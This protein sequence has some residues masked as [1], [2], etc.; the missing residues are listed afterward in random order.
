M[1]P[2]FA[3]VESG[4]R[5]LT[6]TAVD[7]HAR[8]QGLQSGLP[9]ADARAAVPG[10]L[11]RPA[12]RARDLAALEALAVWCGRYGPHR[13]LEGWDGE[14]PDGLWVDVTGVPHLFGGETELVRDL[15]ARLARLGLTARIGLADTPGAAFALA[16]FADTG[17]RSS[18]SIAPAGQLRPALADLPVEALRLPHECVLV[19]KRLGLR[20]IGQLYDLPR[21]ALAQ[22]F[23]NGP[24]AEKG[25]SV[26]KSQREAARLAGLVLMRLDQAL[27]NQ[28]EPR[29]PLLEPP[30][31]LVRRTFMEPLISAPGVEHAVGG[32][33]A[34]LCDL[35]ESQARGARR[36]VLDMYR[37]DATAARIGIGLSRPGRDPGHVVALMVERLCAID[38]GFGIDVMTLAAHE[39]EVLK[40][41]QTRLP[42][43]GLAAAVADAANLIDRL[44]NRLGAASVVRLEAADSHLPE[45]AERRVPA[46]S[47]PASGAAATGPPAVRPLALRPSFLLPRPEPI[48]VLA[49][50]PEGPP[51]RFTWRRLTRR[52]TRADGPE[53]IE[54]EWWRT[55]GWSADAV[56]RESGLGRARDYYAVED[57]AGAR[58]WVFRA[59]LYGRDLEEGPPVWFLH[60]VFA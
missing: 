40:H 60:G 12:E 36:F 59:G 28:L 4:P 13:N 50:V 41:D 29:A 17:Q 44:S 1:P 10:L 7:E 53:R 2:P 3:L 6:L 58:Y 38:A 42:A 19:L 18:W 30:A 32:L 22:R 20:R 23:R 37:T 15:A 56:R 52:V 14:P 33:V 55:I 48:A 47:P 5:G 51:I 27:G 43:G 49:E 16:R 57:E 21:Q 45:R 9:L 26:R 46:L 25:R 11:T 54:P 34:D 31:H 35:L 39:V 24:R 8:A